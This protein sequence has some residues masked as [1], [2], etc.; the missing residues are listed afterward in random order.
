MIKIIATAVAAVLTY[1][2]AEYTFIKLINF[3]FYS[4]SDASIL[5]TH[6]NSWMGPNYS[7]MNVT[8]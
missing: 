3:L 7:I 4:N 6:I 2:L 5:K 1:F 8:T